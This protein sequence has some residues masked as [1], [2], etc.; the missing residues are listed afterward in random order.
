MEVANSA[1]RL[2][3]AFTGFGKLH[4]HRSVEGLKL[5]EVWVLMT[6]KMAI[7]NGAS[8]IKISDISRHLGIASPTVTQLVKGLERKGHVE[9]VRDDRDRRI[10]NV[11]LTGKGE[12]G[13]CAERKELID[14][15]KDLVGYLGEGDSNILAD[16]IFKTAGYIKDKGY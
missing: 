8:G 2:L 13:M 3:E 12:S 14:F 15:F 5:S 6:I 9:R 7:E 1:Q 4:W 11:R 10:V 16:L